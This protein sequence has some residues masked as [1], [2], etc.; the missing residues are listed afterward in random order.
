MV[1]RPG[2]GAWSTGSF[3]LAP[4]RASISDGMTKAAHVRAQSAVDGD[5]EPVRVDGWVQVLR[6]MMHAEDAN[7]F[8]KDCTAGSRSP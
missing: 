2:V 1:T 5:E 6:E 3:Q 4:C 7:G 8:H